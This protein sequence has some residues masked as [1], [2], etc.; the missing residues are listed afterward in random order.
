MLVGLNTTDNNVTFQR[1]LTAGELRRYTKTVKEGLGVLDKK[2]GMIVHHSTAPSLPKQNVG[3]GSLLTKT[4]E[5]SFLPFLAA[6]AY[7]SI[8]QEPD[9]I[10]G[11]YM[12][13]PYSPVSTSKNIFMIPL[14][15][16]ASYEYENLL[17]QKTFQDIVNENA[18]RTNK[19]DVNYDF[20]ARDYN[21]ALSEAYNNFTNKKKPSMFLK[22]L[23]NEFD[24]FK[25]KNHKELVPNAIYEILA[26]KNNN[27]DWKTWPVEDRNLYKD[28]NIKY[29]QTLIRNNEDQIDFHMFKQ[30]LVEREITKAAEINKKNGIKII[31][32][33]PVAFT[34]VEVWQNQDLFFDELSLGCPPDGFSPDGQKWGFAVLKPEK[35]FNKDGSLGEGGKLLKARY[36]KMFESASGGIRIDHIIGLIDPFVYNH[37]EPKMNDRNSGRLYSSPNHPLLGKYAKHTDE[38]YAALLQKII[39]PAAEKYGLTKKD[40]ICEDLGT[41]TE[42]V[43][44]V[45]HKLG[46][47]GIAVT[48][49][50]YRGR[51]MSE[52]KVI[53]LGSHDNCSFVEFTDA[54]FADSKQVDKSFLL[55][56]DTSVPREDRETYRRKIASD[57]KDFMSASFTELFT[58]PAKR[59]QVFFTDF[60]G[61]GKTYNRP[62]TTEG[63]WSLR[64]PNDF[65]DLYYDNLKKGT[66]MNLPDAIA[67]AIRQKGEF[68]ERR[69]S[70]LLS[71]LDEFTRILKS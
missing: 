26:V 2:L 54:M 37:T 28:N 45:M 42:P 15:R 53:M 64:V 25:E 48:E 1:K 27:E 11:N 55:A 57:K 44:N 63:C 16:L 70:E 8:Q 71:R 17:S 3:I 69:Y 30:W 10:R 47:S 60:F 22:S 5:I 32:D 38:E 41:V 29:L 34:S 40:I 59:V 7:S 39:I 13:S 43:R 35:I 33:S 14:E 23:M 19:N 12:P 61:I 24:T 49:F 56:E 4:A 36:E 21:K 66:A 62:G 20:V 52:D 46:L 68:F 9:Y 51:Y 18:K 67:R 31:G 65:E 50:G 6:H 58:S